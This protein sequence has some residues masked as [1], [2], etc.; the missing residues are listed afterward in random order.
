MHS[1][2][3][4]QGVDWRSC[5]PHLSKVALIIF[6]LH[7]YPL[8]NVLCFLKLSLPVLLEV[9]V[10]FCLYHSIREVLL[11]DIV[12]F[13]IMK[14]ARKSTP[15][16]RRM[17]KAL[18]TLEVVAAEEESSKDTKLCMSYDVR[19]SAF[20]SPLGRPSKLV[21]NGFFP[22]GHTIIFQK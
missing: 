4:W 19:C 18:F 10:S 22:G 3:K 2:R 14:G 9:S 12:G 13:R 1:A 17:A 16:H 7:S 21:F 6:S 15:E 5:S 11:L 20:S 8:N